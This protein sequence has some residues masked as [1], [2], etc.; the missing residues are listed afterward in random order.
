MS[1]SVGDSVIYKGKIHN[2]LEKKSNGYFILDNKKTGV[3]SSSIKKVDEPKKISSKSPKSSKH[4]SLQAL[5]PSHKE[6]HENFYDDSEDDTGMP[7]EE[8]QLDYERYTYDEIKN[9]P[10]DQIINL[11]VKIGGPDS[12]RICFKEIKDK[13]IRTKFLQDFDKIYTLKSSVEEIKGDEADRAIEEARS[14]DIHG[15]KSGKKPSKELQNLYQRYLEEKNNYDKAI[16]SGNKI[17]IED[18]FNVMTKIKNSLRERFNFDVDLDSIESFDSFG[19]IRQKSYR[20]KRKNS[21]NKVVKLGVKRVNRRSNNKRRPL[22]VGRRS[23]KNLQRFSRGIYGLQH[24]PVYTGLYPMNRFPKGSPKGIINPMN[25]STT[26]P[27]LKLG[28]DRFTDKRY[29]NSF[30][31]GPGVGP[32]QQQQRPQQQRPQQPRPQRPQIKGF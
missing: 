27:V 14:L 24:G 22:R 19:K 28:P 21:I 2:I 7:V 31:L 25:I 8:S 5:L 18:K 26:L 20:R 10:I 23:N 17:A 15:P 1:L 29:L 11:M 30:G 13:Q 9:K 32:Q 3:R 4:T 12:F 6:E 16:K